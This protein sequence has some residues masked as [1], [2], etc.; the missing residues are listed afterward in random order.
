MV[1]FD[2]LQRTVIWETGVE[3]AH[4][5]K[6]NKKNLVARTGLQAGMHLHTNTHTHCNMCVHERKSKTATHKLMFA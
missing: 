1:L 4:L 3:E 6:K 2:W 5:V